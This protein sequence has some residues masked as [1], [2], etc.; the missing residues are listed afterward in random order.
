MLLSLY[1]DPKIT[2]LLVLEWFS[3]VKKE[4]LVSVD[5]EGNVGMIAWISFVLRK[6]SFSAHYVNSGKS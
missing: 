6:V 1:V 4:G 3:C 2:Y 5:E